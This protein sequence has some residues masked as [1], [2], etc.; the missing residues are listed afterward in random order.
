MSIKEAIITQCAKVSFDEPMKKHTTFRIGGNADIFCEP[1]NAEELSGLI[2]LLTERNEGYTVIGNGSNVLV[3]DEGIRGVVI[4]IGDA[5][6]EVSVCGEKI[7]AGAGILLSR[8]A[9]RAMNEGLSGMECISGIPG[10]LGGAVYMNA[11]AYGAEIADIIDEVTYVSTDGEILTLKKE[12][13]GLGYRKSIFMEN[14]GLVTSC[15]LRLKKGDREKIAEDMA[16]ITKRRVDKQPLELP[17]AGS[18]FKRPEGYFAGRLIEDC[19]LKGYSYGGAGV[20]EKHAG[21]VVN[22]ANASAG[23]VL[24]V[25]K[26]VQEKVY[27]KFGVRLEPEIRFIGF[28]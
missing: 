21:F 17:S 2:K 28:N 22:H 25:I 27:E 19:G 11:G 26:H 8:L 23:D 5:M 20:S 16:E 6:S 9:K 14:G 4:K 18:T 12:A 15:T 3:S 13:L 24:A 10:S 7:T 1:Q